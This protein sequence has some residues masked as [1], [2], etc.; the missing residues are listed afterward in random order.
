MQKNNAKRF[1]WSCAGNQ[2]K[3]AKVI[4]ISKINVDTRIRKKKR[5]TYINGERKLRSSHEKLERK[6]T[7]GPSSAQQA[8][9]YGNKTTR[10]QLKTWKFQI[11]NGGILFLHRKAK[12]T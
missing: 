10:K 3:L 9:A 8:G 6:L 2:R 11:K 7:D 1:S 4:E 12:H 5:V